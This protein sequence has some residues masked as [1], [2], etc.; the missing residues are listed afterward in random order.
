MVSEDISEDNDDK[1]CAGTSNDMDHHWNPVAAI[2][3]PISG[4]GSATAIVAARTL[5]TL[6]RRDVGQIFPPNISPKHSQ[7]D[8]HIHDLS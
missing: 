6:G 3:T 5:I 2:I 4:A 7:H 1:N 8:Q